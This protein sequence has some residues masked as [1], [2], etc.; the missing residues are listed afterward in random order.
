MHTDYHSFS[1]DTYIFFSNL[2]MLPPNKKKTK[3]MHVNIVW[4]LACNT[5]FMTGEGSLSISLIVGGQ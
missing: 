2:Y 4:P 5:A 3:P 1:S